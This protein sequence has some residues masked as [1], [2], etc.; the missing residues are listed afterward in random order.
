LKRWFDQLRQ[1]GFITLNYKLQVLAL[2]IKEQKATPGVS[3][4]QLLLHLAPVRS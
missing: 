3:D 4:Q 2:V 1:K